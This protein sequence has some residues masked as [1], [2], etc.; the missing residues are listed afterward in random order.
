M[1]TKYD[2]VNT[3]VVNRRRSLRRFIVKDDGDKI[4]MKINS[5]DVEQIGLFGAINIAVNYALT[6]AG[7][8]GSFT[9]REFDEGFEVI[10]EP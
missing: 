6:N 4:R 10:A 1:T 2:R 3:C 7:F 9:I 8:E 5:R